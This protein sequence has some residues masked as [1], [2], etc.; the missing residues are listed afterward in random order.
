MIRSFSSVWWHFANQLNSIELNCVEISNVWIVSTVGCKKKN[1]TF[2]LWNQ[3]NSERSLIIIRWL[4]VI[5]PEVIWTYKFSW[6]TE[7]NE[8][9]L[10]LKCQFIIGSAS[11]KC[12]PVKNSLSYFSAFIYFRT[13]ELPP[14]NCY[15]TI[16][17]QD[18]LDCN[19]FQRRLWPDWTKWWCR[20]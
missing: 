12:R 19:S 6:L 7:S 20:Y 10:W 18:S 11:A 9:K 2:S 1:E 5:W 14:V 8:M 13:D 4:P 17:I 16:I 3:W 15:Y